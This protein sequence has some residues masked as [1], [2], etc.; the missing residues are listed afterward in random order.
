VVA[1][2][3][4]SYFARM[5]PVGFLFL[6]AAVEVPR[7]RAVGLAA[8]SRFPGSVPLKREA[9]AHGKAATESWN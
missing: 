3:S 7:R 9:E 1:N 5:A 8:K 2:F 6:L 4:E